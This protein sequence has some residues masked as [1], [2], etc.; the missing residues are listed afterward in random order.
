MIC[1]NWSSLHESTNTD[2]LGKVDS[3]DATTALCQAKLQIVCGSNSAPFRRRRR[4]SH[5]SPF[6]NNN[7]E[8]HELNLI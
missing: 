5:L 6:T 4:E 7:S 3:N 1:M 8:G 2:I